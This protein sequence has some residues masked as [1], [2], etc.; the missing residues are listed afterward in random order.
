MTE[1]MVAMNQNS[2]NPVPNPI[3]EA[4]NPKPAIGDG[5]PKNDMTGNIY[6]GSRFEVL[7]SMDQTVKGGNDMEKKDKTRMGNV[8][9]GAYGPNPNSSSNGSKVVDGLI[10]LRPQK[11]NKSPNTC[12]K[13]GKESSIIPYAIILKKLSQCLFLTRHTFLFII[14]LQSLN[15]RWN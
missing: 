14:V 9:Y 8:V 10:N 3:K 1:K 11:P 7:R 2:A 13:I 15:L 12:S 4:R 5:L 6:K